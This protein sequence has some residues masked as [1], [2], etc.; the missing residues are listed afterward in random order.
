MSNPSSAARRSCRALNAA[1]AMRSGGPGTHTA[2]SSP[3]RSSRNAAASA[4]ICARAIAPR[5][6]AVLIGRPGRRTQIAVTS[7]S[8]TLVAPTV[9]RPLTEPSGETVTQ[10][11]ASSG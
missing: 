11:D 1:D 10:H 2:G 6:D 7:S 3:H 5:C 4:D 9:S 8:A